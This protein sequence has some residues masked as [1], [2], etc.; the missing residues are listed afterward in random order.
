MINKISN[1][2]DSLNQ[3]VVNASSD[4]FDIFIEQ[5]GL[6]N[7]QWEK[8]KQKNQDLNQVKDLTTQLLNLSLT[9]REQL[10]RLNREQLDAIALKAYRAKDMAT[11]QDIFIEIQ[12]REHREKNNVTIDKSLEFFKNPLDAIKQKL[13]YDERNSL[14]KFDLKKNSIDRAKD[15]ISSFEER[16]VSEIRNLK[17]SEDIE[18][19]GKAVS[20]ILFNVWLLARDRKYQDIWQN[21]KNN[22]VEASVDTLWCDFENIEKFMH[23]K[24]IN[25]LDFLGFV[26]N[27]FSSDWIGKEMVIAPNGERYDRQ[28]DTSWSPLEASLYILK[29]SPYLSYGV[30][31]NLVSDNYESCLYNTKIFDE[32]INKYNN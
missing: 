18:K 26:D 17:W 5:E 32:Y 19:T 28:S 8:D 2:E 24:N 6:K 12:N 1:W 29:K 27:K 25:F 16:A 9:K 10:S 14:Q 30:A 20:T 3:N 31:K 7:I 13:D 22:I 21:A 4:E 15:F 23:V 11:V